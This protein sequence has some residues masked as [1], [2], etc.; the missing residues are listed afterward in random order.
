[1]SS[2]IHNLLDDYGT[3]NPIDV[4]L[5]LWEKR[6]HALLVVLSTAKPTP[7][8]TTD[9]LRRGVE[10][11]E[12][13]SYRQWSYYDRW[14]AAITTILLERG[15]I[16]EDA[17]HRQLY[18]DVIDDEPSFSVGDRCRIKNEGPTIRWRKPHLRTPGYIYGLHGVITHVVGIFDDPSLKAFR[19]HGP[20][21][22]LYRIA[23]AMKEVLASQ[24]FNTKNNR[25]NDSLET[26]RN[27]TLEIEIY[28]P[29]LEMYQEKEQESTTHLHL[30]HDHDHEH[31]HNHDHH[32]HDHHDHSHEHEHHHHHDGQKHDHG[33][34]HEGRIELEDRA[35]TLEGA[36]DASPGIVYICIHT[37]AH[38]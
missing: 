23:I 17:L 28:Q 34:E 30:V 18:G 26:H 8:L 7:L 6:I 5:T 10:S 38:V 22:P 13:E 36:S 1:M 31:S 37:C 14:A 35:V 25:G 33:H 15:V 19:S 12:E 20:K 24:Y 27:D 11:L 32:S 21:Q 9:E 4:P 16:T 2:Y 29:W 3:L